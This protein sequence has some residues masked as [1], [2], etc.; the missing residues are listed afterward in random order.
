[1]ELFKNIRFYVLLTSALLAGAIYTW[2]KITIPNEPTA[3]IIKLTQAYAL[4]AVT[5]LYIALLTTPITRIFTFLPFRGH[6]IKARRAIGVSA[7]LF[8]LLH[9][10][11]AFFGELGGFHGLGFLGGKYLLA[12]GFS[13]TALGFE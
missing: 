9:A 13:F 10:S 12:I 11:F 8:S 5:Y 1:M 7:F 4:V 2:I 3:Q 6:Y